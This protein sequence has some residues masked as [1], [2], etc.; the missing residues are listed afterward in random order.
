MR[1]CSFLPAAT[2]IICELGL[3]DQLVG[4]T[5][6]CELERPRVVRSLLEGERLSSGEIDRRVREAK[7]SGGELY[8]IDE[9]LLESLAPDIIFTQDVCSVCQI[10]TAA[11]SR[12]IS[13]LPNP[14]RL[15]P[16][17]PRTLRD[18][19]DTI[20]EVA[21]ALGEPARGEKL[22]A[23]LDARTAKVE[24]RVRVQKNTVPLRVSFLEWADPIY[25]S[26]HWI[27]EQ[28]R[29]A[30]GEDALGS[31]GG[32]SAAVPFEK[33]HEYNPEVIVVS[34]CG[35]DKARSAAEI[36]KL[37][38]HSGWRDIAAVKN[39]R[40]YAA[41]S[42]LFT[43]PGPRLVDGIELLEKL[44]HFAPSQNATHS[45]FDVTVPPQLP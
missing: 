9:T 41:D 8:W 21:V 42:K 5:F 16:L 28:V 37:E 13:R 15:V 11:V 18:V 36:A 10:D 44:F 17:A 30:G 1:A 34:A 24:A 43:E 29:A 39:G 26:G 38:G 12:A 19:F 14:P 27:P 32:Y 45:C 2:S 4:V 23:E 40:V 7:E 6:E 31:P 3:S 25:T 35:F 20:R 33:I 22:T